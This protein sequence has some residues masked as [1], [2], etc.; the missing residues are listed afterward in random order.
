MLQI[1]IFFQLK[2]INNKVFRNWRRFSRLTVFVVSLTTLSLISF[3]SAEDEVPR[4]SYDHNKEVHDTTL[5]RF[6]SEFIKNASR[7]ELIALRREIIW[8]E[9]FRPLYRINNAHVS[10][11]FDI[12]DLV[13]KDIS[14][15]ELNK[16]E[17]VIMRK[18]FSIT[19]PGSSSRKSI[20]PLG[21]SRFHFA[22]SGDERRILESINLYLSREL[23]S[24]I[25]DFKEFVDID[26]M[27]V[28]NP[29]GYQDGSYRFSPSRPYRMHEPNPLK[30]LSNPS[31]SGYYLEI[32]QA[33]KKQETLKIHVVLRNDIPT[34]VGKVL[35]EL[36]GLDI[37]VIDRT[38]REFIATLDEKTFDVLIRNQDISVLKDLDFHRHLL[39]ESGKWRPYPL[40]ELRLATSDEILVLSRP[41]KTNLHRQGHE[42]I[43]T[44]EQLDV[45]LNS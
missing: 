3:A 6:I 41:V 33:F 22:N 4:F 5:A 27:G 15:K 17:S 45:L 31:K 44:L 25:T 24:A 38:Q 40:S 16:T 12:T 32:K 35:S 20:H 7:E 1:Y 36:N 11:L 14:Y 19:T 10:V 28:S 37:E 43:E 8:R 18:L 26:L 13:P 30:L 9:S 42:V 34:S 2:T 21:A 39:K 29:T 23:F